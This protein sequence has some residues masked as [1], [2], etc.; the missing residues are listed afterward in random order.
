MHRYPEG[1]VF[2]S[3]EIVPMKRITYLFAVATLLAALVVA[4]VPAFAGP[5]VPEVDPELPSG[6][7]VVCRSGNGSFS[8]GA[9]S[10][11]Q[12]CSASDRALNFTHVLQDFDLTAP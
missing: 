9:A 10:D 2:N 4:Q 12:R 3:Q 11:A 8:W 5:A 1:H 7:I 6:I